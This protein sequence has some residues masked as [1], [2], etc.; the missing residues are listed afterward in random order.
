MSNGDQQQAT[1]TTVDCPDC[2]R[3]ADKKPLPGW[4]A[5]VIILVVLILGGFLF[6]KLM[7]SGVK[8]SDEIY[9]QLL[10]PSRAA[11]DYR[12]R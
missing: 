3:P 7:E 9:C 10:T 12:C 5:I 4:V 6:T 11:Q 1:T 2:G 8:S